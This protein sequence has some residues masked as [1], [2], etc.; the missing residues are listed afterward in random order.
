MYLNIKY[1]SQCPVCE[2]EVLLDKGE[3]DFPRRIVGRCQESP[4]EHVYSF[5][6]VTKTGMR[7]R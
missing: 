5:D 4:R 7:L 2:A 1:A 6:R 3:P